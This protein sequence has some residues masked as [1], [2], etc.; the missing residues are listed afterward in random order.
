MA[1]QLRENE[2]IKAE[3]NFHWSAFIMAK[4]WA[5]LGVLV[6][7]GTIVG[8]FSDKA[9]EKPGVIFS[10]IFWTLIFF[11]PFIYKWLQNK[12]KTYVVTNQRVYIEE[13]LLSKSKRDLPLNKVNDIS[14][15][16]GILQRMFGSGNIVILMGNDKPT[17]VKD[18]EN[19]DI[20]KNA[21]SEMLEKK[22]AS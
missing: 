8:S 12:F 15:K 21:I 10:G 5:G 20:F 9:E 2:T 7:L 4:I 14:L 17:I 3:V 19:P 16:Q 11:S 1:I 13:G 18:I 6:L 22:N